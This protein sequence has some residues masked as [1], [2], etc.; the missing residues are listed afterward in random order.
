M[1]RYA[2]LRPPHGPLLEA[3]GVSVGVTVGI[4]VGVEVGVGAGAGVGVAVGDGVSVCFIVATRV[5][6]VVILTCAVFPS[7]LNTGPAQLSS[8]QPSSGRTVIV[9][10]MSFMYPCLLPFSKGSGL[11]R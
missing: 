6:V 8:S 3:M 4:G 1:S 9:T 7:S 5:R 11:S 2:P 10:V